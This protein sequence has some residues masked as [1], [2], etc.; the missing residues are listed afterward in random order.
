MFDQIR[1]LL[2]ASVFVGAYPS[3][4]CQYI[5]ERNLITKIMF[6]EESWSA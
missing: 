6:C 1:N 4:E 3:E 5:L 2:T